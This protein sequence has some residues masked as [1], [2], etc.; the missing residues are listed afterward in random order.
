MKTYQLRLKGT[1]KN[2]TNDLTIIIRGDN[3]AQA[4]TWAYWFFEKGE[5]THPYFASGINRMSG[6]TLEFIPEAD[7]MMHLAGKFFVPRT[8][9][10]VIK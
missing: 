8:A 7:K 2:N 3:K 5:F 4:F 6:G 9:I 1:K 10:R